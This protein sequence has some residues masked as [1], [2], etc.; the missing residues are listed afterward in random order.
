MGRI[1]IWSKLFLDIV[2]EH[3]LLIGDEKFIQ[4]FITEFREKCSDCDL[5][6]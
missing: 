4:D 2:N 6:E 5:E 1:S 3:E